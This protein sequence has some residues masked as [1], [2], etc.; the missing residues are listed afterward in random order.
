MS[1]VVSKS[2]ETVQKALEQ[3]G[4]TCRVVEFTSST[5]TASDAANTIGCEVS[6]IVKS[7]LF[8]TKYTNMPVLILASGKN[9]VEE[10]VIEKFI[11]E[12][13]EKANADF[14]REVTGFAIGGIPPIGHKQRIQ[15]IFIDEDLLHNETIWAAAGTP[16]TVFSMPSSVLQDLTGGMV[17]SIRN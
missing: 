16:F 3:R 8:R 12:K 2:A 7:L 10:Q 13:I 4:L 5:R 15:H 14:T 1:Q 6:Q 11:G 9:R 17:I